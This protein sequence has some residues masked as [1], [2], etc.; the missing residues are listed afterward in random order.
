MLLAGVYLFVIFCHTALVTCQGSLSDVTYDLFGGFKNG[1]VAAFGDFNAD[2]LTDIFVLS[3]AGKFVVCFSRVRL[4][5][6][7][8]FISFLS[9]MLYKYI[10]ISCCYRWRLMSEWHACTTVWKLNMCLSPLKMKRY[11][12][13]LITGKWMNTEYFSRFVDTWSNESERRACNGC[14]FI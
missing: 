14:Y 2:K 7:F 13:T 4:D 5:L 6:S 11:W 12:S 8:T 10:Y 9:P 3:D 1:V